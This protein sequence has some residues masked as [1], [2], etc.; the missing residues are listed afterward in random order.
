M[1]G[2]KQ[3]N[4]ECEQ[5]LPFFKLLKS[6]VLQ[7]TK[8]RLCK[9]IICLVITYEADILILKSIF[10]Q[11]VRLSLRYMKMVTGE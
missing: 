2:N 9:T 4:H 7:K 8:V 1:R 10:E 11:H 6:N 3:E 5:S